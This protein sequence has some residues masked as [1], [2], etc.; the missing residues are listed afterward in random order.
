MVVDIIPLLLLLFLYIDAYVLAAM[1]D[2]TSDSST[3]DSLPDL[4]EATSIESLAPGGPYI[5]NSD[6]NTVEGGNTISSNYGGI[7]GTIISSQQGGGATSNNSLP[8]LQGQ[9]I[10]IMRSPFS[11]P[12]YQQTSTTA[13]L[14]NENL[15]LV[16]QEGHQYQGYLGN[17]IHIQLPGVQHTNLL[18]HSTRPM[19]QPNR[20][21]N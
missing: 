19:P 17:D 16:H 10:L 13:C 7:N 20:S 4:L 21:L 15:S 1:D 3:R 14:Q 8:L 9:Q 6:N 5:E 11:E 18:N 12:N 2:S